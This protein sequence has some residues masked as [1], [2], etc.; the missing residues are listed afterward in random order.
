MSLQKQLPSLLD[1]VRNP[2]LRDML[3]DKVLAKLIEDLKQIPTLGAGGTH[4][5][6]T[7][8]DLAQKMTKGQ[9]KEWFPAKHLTYLSEVLVKA[10][11]EGNGR[12][13]VSMPPR[14]G[15]SELISYWFV[16]WCLARDP[17]TEVI[18]TSYEADFAAKW[19]RRVRNAILDF[20][21]DLGLLLDG[22]SAAADRWQLTAGGGMVTAGA[23]GPITGRG[24]NLLIIDDPIKNSE[25]ARSPKLRENLWEWFQTTAFSRLEP[26]ATVVL[27]G[28]RWHEDDLIGRLE[29]DSYDEDGV[30]WT[31][32]KFPALAEANDPLGREIDEPLWPERIPKSKLIEIKKINSPYNFSAIYQQHPTPEGSGSVNRKWWKTYMVPPMEFDQVIQSWDLAFK[33]LADGSYTVGQVWGRRGAE[34]YLLDQVR[35]HLDAPKTIEAFRRMWSKWPQSLAKLVEDKANGPAVMALLHHEIPGL[36][37]V[38]PKGN[39]HMRLSA[40]VP[41][42]EAGNVYIPHPVN[43]RWVAEFIEEHAG[44]PNSTNDDQVD[45]TSQ[46]LTYLQPQGWL[47]ISRDWRESKM[48]TAPTNPQEA[49]RQEFHR[50]FVKKAIE[51]SD[52]RIAQQMRGSALTQVRRIKAW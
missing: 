39:K 48:P 30:P 45:A 37:P 11:N 3:P 47:S 8:G 18:L 12:I 34:F 29:K 17:T 10:V 52:K 20:G 50:T 7:P 15:K 6:P 31:V 36:I 32:I 51:K 49:M 27:I 9:R 5:P 1:L 14:H 35:E 25:E 19:G 4:V 42:I 16:L 46:A 22:S 40:V 28:T 44:F 2:E 26:N 41:L 13:L 21:A 24:A 38:K 43:A 23:G 33:D